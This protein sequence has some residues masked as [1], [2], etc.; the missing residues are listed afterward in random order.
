MTGFGSAESHNEDHTYYC[1]IKSVNSRFSDISIRLPR[2]FSWLETELIKLTKTYILRGKVEL[3]LQSFST[4]Q[5]EKLPELNEIALTHYKGIYE[6]LMQS[7]MPQLSAPSFADL[8]QLEGMRKIP[9]P[10]S[11]SELENKHRKSIELTVCKALEQLVQDREKEGLH[12]CK[13]MIGQ[14]D[15]IEAHRNIID[16]QSET[17]RQQLSQQTYERFDK[18]KH[19]PVF[20]DK[21][22][23]PEDE[24]L[25][26]EITIILD[27]MDIAEELTRISAH[28]EDFRDT[29]NGDCSEGIGRKL[30]FL[31]QELHRE[32]NTI[33]SKLQHLSISKHTIAIKQAVERI[34]QQVQNIE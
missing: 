7:K 16:Q 3:S 23:I 4:K 13:T 28:S 11:I 34:R 9:T 12:L 14:L 1:E 22:A 27:K 32:V 2:K 15:Q 17:I 6:N 5:V 20:R 10:E 33:S 8:W 24:R 19:N 29:L 31:C 30:D 21:I 18:L 26:A 25:L